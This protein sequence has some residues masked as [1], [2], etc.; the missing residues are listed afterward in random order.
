[1]NTGCSLS[2]SMRTVPISS[3]I[4]HCGT[5]EP[6]SR[7]SETSAYEAVSN[8]SL[9]RHQEAVRV[10]LGQVVDDPGDA[11]RQQAERDERE[12]AAGDDR[13]DPACRPLPRGRSFRNRRLRDRRRLEQPRLWRNVGRLPGRAG[14]AGSGPSSA[15][16]RRRPGAPAVEAEHEVEDPSRIAGREQQRD[17]R[18]EDEHRDQARPPVALLPPQEASSPPPTR[19]ATMTYCGM[20]SS[21]HLTRTSPRDSRSG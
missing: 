14:T 6:M 4:T 11:A 10:T 3:S 7:V 18:D 15:P 5:S 8:C 2:L 13:D 9:G 19:I 1:M 21:H 12:D 16:R 17:A 20:A